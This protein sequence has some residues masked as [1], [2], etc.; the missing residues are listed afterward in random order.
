VL[1]CQGRAQLAV[2]LRKGPGREGCAPQEY[3]GL[4]GLGAH[5]KMLSRRQ[6]L[7]SST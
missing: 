1:A 4:Q 5:G 6:A 3:V 2:L 7:P